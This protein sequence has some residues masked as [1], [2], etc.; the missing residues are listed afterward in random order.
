M[1]TFSLVYIFRTASA[2]TG[3]TEA[4]TAPARWMLRGAER[5]AKSGRSAARK[6]F[7]AKFESGSL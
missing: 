4:S 3:L 7:Q 6:I 5:A 2:A 1:T